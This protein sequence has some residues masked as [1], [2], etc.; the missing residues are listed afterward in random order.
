MRTMHHS[1]LAV[2]ATAAMLSACSGN[3]GPGQPN[4]AYNVDG[5]YT[6]AIA[7][8]EHTL[9]GTAEMTIADGGAVMGTFTIFGDAMPI[10]GAVSAD[11]LTFSGTY[12]RSEGCEGLLEGEGVVATGG[13]V[14]TG[15]MSINDSCDGVD[16]GATFEMTR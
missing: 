5:A 6:I 10:T 2:M 9:P 8:F 15:T 14:I 1:R 11:T 4:Y 13:D 3:P 7:A 16:D 12:E